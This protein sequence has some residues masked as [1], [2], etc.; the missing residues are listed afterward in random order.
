MHVNR[1]GLSLRLA[2]FAVFSCL[3]AG[4]AWAAAGDC[5]PQVRDGWIRDPIG[6]MQT[7]LAGYGRI[8]NPCPATVVVVGAE[9]A[10]FADVSIHRTTVA[11]GMSRMRA[12]PELPI[13]PDD[14]AVLEPG[15]M[16]LMLMQ[17]ATTPVVGDH[18]RIDLR[19][20]DGRRIQGDFVVRSP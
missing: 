16:H 1:P 12:V 8:E 20:Q 6:P 3:V 9:S 15:G 19:L 11:D 18:V 2:A 13:A 10:A 7:M 4:Q 17:P 5:A 14:A